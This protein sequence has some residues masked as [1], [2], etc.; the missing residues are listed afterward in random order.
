MAR[1][2]SLP[3]A[4]D[5]SSD[6]T[7]PGSRNETGDGPETHRSWAGPRLDAEGVDNDPEPGRRRCYARQDKVWALDPAG[8]AWEYYAVLEPTETA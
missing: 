5:P 6:R 4:P 1:Y 3:R 8:M 2:D 7:R